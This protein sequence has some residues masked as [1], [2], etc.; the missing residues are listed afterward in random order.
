MTTAANNA[1]IA[2]EMPSAVVIRSSVGLDGK[3]HNTDCLNLLPEIAAES[4]ALVVTSPPYFNAREYAKWNTY[5]E[6]ME[7]CEAWISQCLRVLQPGRMLC[8]NSSS[9]I[10]ARASRGERSRRYNIPADLWKIC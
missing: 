8:I 10:E 7:W 9:V 6:Y 5:A 1:T 3:I 4:I 2:T